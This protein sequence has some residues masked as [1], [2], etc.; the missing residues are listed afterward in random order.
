MM[1]KKKI[2]NLPIFGVRTNIYRQMEDIYEFMFNVFSPNIDYLKKEYILKGWYIEK[3]K[4]PKIKPT[5]NTKEIPYLNLDEKQVNSSKNLYFELL[6]KNKKIQS[7][8]DKVAELE[9][10]LSDL[11]IGSITKNGEGRR[12]QRYNETYNKDSKLGNMDFMDGCENTKK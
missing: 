4:T 10:M 8:E 6:Q 3:Q 7:L 2:S 11:T 5:Q 12:R 1:A 9:D